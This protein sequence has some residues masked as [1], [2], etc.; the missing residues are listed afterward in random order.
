MLATLRF[1]LD[2][3]VDGFRIDVAHR[4]MKDPDLRDN[5]PNPAAHGALHKSLG[6]YD[7]QLHV[8][9]MG[10]PD[11]HP[12][13]REIRALLDS[14]SAERPRVSI[15]EIHVFEWDVW[16]RYYGAQL[17]ELHLPFNFGLL[18]TD[19]SGR[20]VRRLVDTLEAVIPPGGW[21]NYVLGNHDEHRI[22]SRIG[23]EQARVAMLLLLTL[24]GTPTIYYGDEL[25][26]EDV[27]VPDERAQDPWGKRVAGLGLGRD[28][29]R[30]PMQWDGSPNAGFT[31]AGAA[32]WLP[33]AADYREC[34]VE[35]QLAYRRSMLVLTRDLLRLRRASPA[36]STGGYRPVDDVPD[37]CFVFTR[38][39][40]GERCVVLLNFSD[41]ELVLRLPA[42]SRGSIVVSTGLDRS[43]P[44]DLAS[45][46]LRAHEGCVVRVRS[47]G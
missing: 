40:A 45:F 30:T 41:D 7:Q 47:D 42:L 5:P 11:I 27:P 26:M 10:H 33:V 31:T 39:A 21:P 2:R 22:A 13:Y 37:A 44:V 29:E 9:D 38:E 17:D 34:N 46:E 6:E 35:A 18:A 32:P 23:P 19:W 12:L 3:G 25:G 24:R 36:L 15:G 16:S 1:W 4:L 20:A 14:Y 43:G 28:P 8:N